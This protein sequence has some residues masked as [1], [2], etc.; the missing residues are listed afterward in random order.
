[1]DSIKAFID[2]I[3]IQCVIPNSVN[4]AVRFRLS[5]DFITSESF[6]A[7]LAYYSYLDYFIYDN[8]SNFLYSYY[9]DSAMDDSLVMGVDIIAKVQVGVIFLDQILKA[10]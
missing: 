7:V 10:N 2:F 1:M 9:F 8:Y 4:F 5:I 6:N 3:V